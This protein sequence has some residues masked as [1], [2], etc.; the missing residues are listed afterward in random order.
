MTNSRRLQITLLAL[1][2]TF[3]FTNIGWAQTLR[4]NIGWTQ[5]RAEIGAALEDGSGIIAS[6]VE[7]RVTNEDTGDIAYLPSTTNGNFSGKTFYDGSGF[8]T[9][10]TGHATSVGQRLYGTSTT[11]ISGGISD[12][13]GFDADDWLNRVTGLASGGDP[14]AQV[15]G[16]GQTFDVQNH[17]YISNGNGDAVATDVLNRVDFLVNRDNTTIV[18]GANNG[19]GN[20]TPELLAHGYNSITV[21]RTDGNHSRGATRFNGTGRYKPEIVAPQTATSFSTPVVAGAAAILR[22]AGAGT[23][24][25][26][27]EAV[28]AIL[29]AG[30]TKD[31]FGDAFD[32]PSDPSQPL[33]EVYGVGELNVYNSYKI[34]QG[35]EQTGSA[36]SPVII[37]DNQGFDYEENLESGESLY[38]NFDLADGASEVSVALTWNLL[39]EDLDSSAD[40]FDAETTLNDLD[41]AFYD[42]TGSFLG[43]L[44]DSSISTVDNVEHLF[45]RDLDAG[46][47]TLEVSRKSGFTGDQDFA[48]AFTIAVPEPGSALVLILGSMGLVLRRRSRPHHESAS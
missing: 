37:S 7:A 10:F 19:S 25:V 29:L 3:L 18:V 27:N 42:S 47:Y 22:E 40:V 9:G 16:A 8:N 33:H 34:L 11:G 30:A 39:V 20:I 21:G 14:L 2:G 1:V 46:L 35:G 4:D 13:T 6:Q 23:N 12:I 15:N 45:L 43:S 5:L 44:L 41:L 24:A 32:G 38:Y 28:K 48:V 31:E 36:A 17:S 26:Q